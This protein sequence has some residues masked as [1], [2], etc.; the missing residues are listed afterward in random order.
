MASISSLGI[1]SGLDL[2]GLVT[3]LVS[4]E[5]AP[6]DSRL[7]RYESTLTTDLSGVGLMRGALSGFQG[8][9]SSLSNSDNFSNR[10]ISNSQPSEITATVSQ[11]A[12]I[13]SYSVEVSNLASAQSLASSA[14]AALD[15]EVGTGSL[16]IK[17][18]TITGPSF[19]SFTPDASSAIQTITVDSSNNTLS[20][21]KDHINSNDYGVTASIVNDGTGYR[22]T[23]LSDSTGA[24]AAMEITVTDTGDASDTDINGL[25]NLAYNALAQNVTQTQV[26][27]DANLTINGLPITSA[28]N[29]LSEA[30]EGVTLSLNAETAVGVPA[31]IVISEESS[32]I[33]LAIKDLIAGF[34]AM[35]STLNDLSSSNPETGEVGILAGSSVVRSFTS[36]IRNVLTSPVDGLNGDIRAM[37]DI[38]ITTQSDGSLSIDSSKFDAAVAANPLDALGL[39]SAVGQASDSLI[40]YNGSSDSTDEGEYAVNITQLA[41]RAEFT[42]NSVLAF[43]L[44]I[45]ADNDELSLTV[46]GTSTGTIS[47]A[48]DSYAS[49]DD[50]AAE[51]QL[52]INSSSLLQDAEKTVAVSFDAT[53][54]RLVI[55]SGSFGSSSTVAINSV[56]TNTA[57]QLG[58]TAISGADGVDVAGTIGGV[59]GTGDGNTLTI[60]SGSPN[61][62]SIDVEGNSLGDRGTIKFVRGF[63]DTLD[64]L[65]ESYLDSDGV[66]SAREDDISKSL[67]GIKDE[68]DTL[69]LRMEALNVRLVREFSAL[70]ILISQFQTTGEYLSQQLA[71]LPGSTF[72]KN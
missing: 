60:E 61:G 9:L 47:I 45:D 26:A 7:N 38:G 2:S 46:D 20:G 4:A 52:K 3:N 68:R 50:L 57:A 72:D 35:I 36:Q 16:Q 62:I 15:S 34:N 12:S 65:L 67:D 48:Q 8:S 5:R 11:N 6:V 24:N 29:S 28:T 14:Y 30:I 13:G 64:T 63:V 71:S 21:L 58:L 53:N 55:N 33:S 42:G 1:G 40:T 22:L 31:K 23:L 43:P 39:F 32:Q 41:S 25:S 54:S 37:V 66:L 18:G 69:E 19:T 59:P 17:F 51:L 27:K 44:T 56:D 10:K 49:G 70:D